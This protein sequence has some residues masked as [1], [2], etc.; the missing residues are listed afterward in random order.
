MGWLEPDSLLPSEEVI[1]A[2]VSKKE[3]KCH[4]LDLFKTDFEHWLE[5]KMSLTVIHKLV[6]EKA[7]C[8]YTALRTFVHNNFPKHI[9]PVMI[10]NHIIGEIADVD[11]GYMGLCYDP[12]EKRNRKAWVFSLRLRYSRKAFRKIVF[13][14]IAAFAKEA[15]LRRA[16]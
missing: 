6:K 1:Q 14:Q 7:S 16:K 2:A 13:D 9:Q 4:P 3:R 10:R 12:V 15:P 8:S 11:F 5:K